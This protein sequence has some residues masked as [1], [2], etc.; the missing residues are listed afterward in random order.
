MPSNSLNIVFSQ[1]QGVY[2]PGCSVC[3]T[4]QLNLEEPMKAR[5]LTIGI[6][7]SAFTRWSKRRSRTVR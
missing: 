1:P 3:G 2:H 5:S 6:D 4:A 7:G